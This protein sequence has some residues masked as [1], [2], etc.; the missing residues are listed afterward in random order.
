MVL[1]QTYD[2]QLFKSDMFRLFINTF[3]DDKNGIINHYKQSCNISNTQST[4]T[5]SDGAFL[6]QGGLIQVQGNETV[7][8]DL[9]N[10]YCIL[11]FEIDLTKENTETEFNQG[12]FKIIKGTNSTYPTLQQDDIVN[13]STGIYQMEFARFVAN[14]GGITNFVDNRVFIDYQTMFENIDS[15][16][17]QMVEKVD[18]QMTQ[19]IAEVDNHVSQIDTE[20]EQKFDDIDTQM[21]QKIQ[22]IDTEVSQLI[23]DLETRIEQV[24]NIPID[25]DI[26]NS[27]D[28]SGNTFK[29]TLRRQGSI[30]SVQ[31][32]CI[33]QQGAFGQRIK[34]QLGFPDN[35]VPEKYKPRE[36]INHK[37]S[38]LASSG[39]S[40]VPQ[41]YVETL[42]SENAFLV[43][44]CNKSGFSIEM[45]IN[46][47]YFGKDV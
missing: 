15:Q 13:N 8:V 45:Q 18:N 24:G 27:Q 37:Q 1:G 22:N 36:T 38:Y 12:K 42:I 44:F 40:V 21:E 25:E 6:L 3:A 5:I 35:L 16:M 47:M 30:V 34:T 19:K 17:S 14:S 7:N 9:D 2:E 32:S 23:S 29:I 11:A 43:S 41:A 31:I 10:T 33:M 28:D 4:I 46:L 20:V 39:T 26:Y